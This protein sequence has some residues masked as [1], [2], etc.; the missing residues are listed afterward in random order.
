M[1]TWMNLPFQKRFFRAFLSHA[2]VDKNLVDQLFYWLKEKAGIPIWYD[3]INL[4][5]GA[6]IAT[7][8][9]KA[10]TECRSMIIIVSKASIKSGWVKAEYS[11]AMTQ[12]T[13][14]EQYQIISIRIEDCELPDFLPQYKCI[15]AFDKKVDTTLAF[16][17]LATLYY[18]DKTLTLENVLDLYISRSWRS[19]EASLPDYICQQLHKARFR[20]I[21]DSEDQRNFSPERV[22]SL[23]KSCGGLVCILPNRGGG[24]LSKYMLDEIEFAQK[25]D[26]PSLIIAETGVDL[27]GY[28]AQRTTFISTNDIE[29]EEI[30]ATLRRNIEEL[31][32]QWQQP[33]QPYY[34]FLAT[35]FDNEQRNLNI[36]QAIQHITAMPCI[37]GDKLL[38]SHIR[39]LIAE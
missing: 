17:L 15:D 2:D 38:E 13:K 9:P 31:Y 4:P 37:I 19:T 39:E 3:K 22:Q 18:D 8:L 28:L 29:K 1:S 14:Y 7:E 21:G 36:K 35:N 16:E 25:A 27:P 6:N 5:P 34:T 26:L 12:K 24:I 30:N 23:I 33:S 10:I 20:L 32:D 11:A